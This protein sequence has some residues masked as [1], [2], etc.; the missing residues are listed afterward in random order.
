[1]HRAEIR[2]LRHL[3]DAQPHG[4]PRS[5]IPRSC[6]AL[7]TRME[8]CGAVGV[9]HTPRGMLL[10]VQDDTAFERLLLSEL[11]QGLTA[12]FDSLPDRAASIA[13]L[14]SAKGVRHGAYQGV[15]VRSTKPGIHIYRCDGKGS[16]DVSGMTR[17]GGGA[18]IVLSKEDSWTFSGTVA[19]VENEETF[20]NHDVVLPT[21]DLAVYTHGKMSNRLLSWLGSEAM[22]QCEY[23]HWGDYDPIGVNDYRRLARM[24]PGRVR[25]FVPERL[26]ELLA[27]FGNTKLI[28]KQ[29]K[30]LTR[31]RKH[32]A[33]PVVEGMIRLFDLYRR[34]LEQE[35]LLR[36][37][38]D[39]A[40]NRPMLKP[41]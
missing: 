24:C 17:I 4:I 32:A 16:V 2:L 25:F 28:E 23:L 34:G 40:E 1:M 22:S 29:A 3:R 10:R 15:F 36:P 14:A 30:F 8:T 35:L 18:A 27:R 39:M 37:P 11:P 19:T 33:D 26:E 5:S 21:V 31:L 9:V 12:E 20:W 13:A 38:S 7:V 41:N 6:A